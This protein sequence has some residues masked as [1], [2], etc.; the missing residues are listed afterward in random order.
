MPETTVFDHYEVLRRDDGSL[1]ELGRG[2]MGITYKA[3][4]T[5]LRCPVAL[6]V[7]NA[8][9]INSEVARQRFVRE[10]RSAAQLRLR[11]V[12]SVFHLGVEGDTYYYAMEFIDGETIESFVRRSGPLPSI[13]ALRITVQVARALNAAQKHQLVHRDIKPSNLM[14]V[15][16]DEELVVKVIDF[17]LAKSSRSDES[18]A[19]E[20][21]IAGFVGTPHFAS[22]EQLDELDLDVRSDIYSLGV[23][24][25]YM[26]TGV[27]PF[28]GTVAQVMSHHLH[29]QPPLE[30]IRN[31]PASVRNLLVSMLAKDPRRRPQTPLELR[32]ALESCIDEIAGTS[33]GSPVAEPGVVLLSESNRRGGAVLRSKGFYAGAIVGG[34]YELLRELGESNTGWIF[35]AE[36]SH[37][38]S[39]LRL[40]VLGADL[41]ADS[42]ALT[43]IEREVEK[44]RAI[45]HPNILRVLGMEHTPEANYIL[46]EWTDG[47]SLLELLRSRREIDGDET[48]LL[49][50]QISA[51]VDEAVARGLRHVDF[52]LSQILVHFPGGE[53]QPERRLATPVDRWPQFNIKINALGIAQEFSASDTWAGGQTMVADLA[54]AAARDSAGPSTR[55]YIQSL[56]AVVYELLGG[57]LSPVVF[58]G[59]GTLPASRYVPVAALPEAGNEVVRQALDP[60]RAFATAGEFCKALE[61]TL[62]GDHRAQP[63]TAVPPPGFATRTGSTSPGSVHLPPSAPAPPGPRRFHFPWLAAAALAACA[64]AGLALWFINRSASAPETA[65]AV[66]AASPTPEAELPVSTPPALTPTPAPPTPAPP[67]PS[68]PDPNALMKAKL[69]EGEAAETAHD[70]PR[71]VESYVE[72]TRDFPGVDSGRVRVET[73]LASQLPAIDKMPPA[74][75]VPLRPA[76]ADAAAQDI[77]SAM[78]ILGDRLRTEA[79]QEA[80]AWYCAAAVRGSA[81][82][83]TQAGL[84]VSNGAG[85]PRDYAK[86]AAWFQWAA[87]SGDVAGKTCLAEC[88]LYGTG[89]PKDE[90]H[91]I[92]LL[93]EAVA[94]GDV[95]AM[96]TLG[97]CYHRGAGVT[98]NFTQAFNLFSRAHDA[99]FEDAAGNLGVLYM[100]GDGVAQDPPKAVDLFDEGAQAGSA[101]CMYQLAR[102]LQFGTGITKNILQAG[103]WYRKAALGG[104][105]MALQWCRD[106]HVA[107]QKP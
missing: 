85:T 96:N 54:A 36:D 41:A 26:L 87:A 8:A 9:S 93:Q 97:T 102:C 16:E 84:M 56:G 34:R 10:A 80:F 106:N 4:D 95:R 60:H 47:F 12:A 77:V 49:L 75:F 39:K 13:L 67:A 63:A 105:P 25:W 28:G 55:H 61:A 88:Y 38:G 14:L 98:Q 73:L 40:L 57:T 53:E 91:A 71:A 43:Q 7:I 3:F 29:S 1:F 74:D 20:A 72:F 78:V 19:G 24:L 92:D 5:N 23:T 94:A 82:A 59:L 11:L 89:L 70:W 18:T 31:L 33:P 46:I 62:A 21:T 45:E 104:N 68:T 17:G 101:Y 99:G 51:G 66:T 44:L 6:K 79:P 58:G 15:H 22:P 69:A 37:D 81:S 103:E 107:L 50:R 30:R 65:A 100:N 2:A 86:A 90:H 64:L 27:A 52:S 42:A 48:L 83:M 76:I 35:Q 32:A